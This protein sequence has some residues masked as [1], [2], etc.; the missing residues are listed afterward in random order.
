MKRRPVRPEEHP[1]G[2]SLYRVRPRINGKRKVVIAGVS[3]PEALEAS[4]AYEQLRDKRE[5][6]DG[7]TLAAFGL[8]FLDRRDRAGVKGIKQERQRW[9]QYVAKD[10]L[11]ALAI[12]TLERRD[13]LDW[14]DRWSGSGFQTLSNALNL[15]QLALDQALDRDLCKTNVARSVKV[16]RG[17]RA[18]DRDELE[19]VLLP[20]EQGALL[21]AIPNELDRLCVTFALYSGMRQGSQWA[22]KRAD[23]HGDTVTLR[24]HKSGRVRVLHLLPPARDALARSLELA[25]ALGSE[26]AFPAPRGERRHYG[27]TPV[28][29]RDHKVKKPGKPAR[30]IPGWLS[31]AGIDRRVRW[32][33]LRHT[34]ATALLAGWWG[35]PP[36]KWSLDEVCSYLQHSSVKVTER[37]AKKLA[38][39]ELRAV[40]E[41]RFA[42]PPEPQLPIIE[43]PILQEFGE[44]RIGFEPTCDGF[45]TSPHPEEV[46]E[47]GSVQ[48][49]TRGRSVELPAREA[50]AL[51]A[52][53]VLRGRILVA[54]RSVR[55]RS[56]KGAKRA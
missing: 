29:W 54:Q 27:K 1:K 23:C 47:L 10:A 56:K 25:A 48:G 18:K 24:R 20:A 3:Y 52:E 35:S 8:G 11:G 55:T 14:L 41:T 50:L 26:Y 53:A 34:C 2:S 28:G 5:I 51:A 7:I 4:R 39:T 21:G 49:P 32:H 44:A 30:L 40:T 12:A 36:R 6:E 46:R 17:K 38:E 13:V 9:A 15:V 45:A 19:G 37:Y 16:P 43:L 33:D 31:K 42:A 22:L